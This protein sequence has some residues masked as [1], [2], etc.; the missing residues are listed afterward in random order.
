VLDYLQMA[1]DGALF[2][3]TYALV[4]I[5]FTLVFGVMRRINM[6]Y[7]AASLTAAY[8]GLTASWFAP[9]AALLVLAVSTVVGGAIGLVIYI[10]CF[11]FIPQ[12]NELATLL[13]SIGA[14]LTFEEL[15]VHATQGMPTAYPSIIEGRPWRLGLLSVRPDLVAVFLICCLA[16]AA[17]LFILYRTRLGMATRAISQQPV[18]ARLCGV[19]LQRIN[20]ST[21]ALT[22]GLGG[23][24][25]ALVGTAVGVLS[26]MLTLPLSIKGLIVAVIGG[27]GS[28]P[29]AIVAGI[30]IG[31]VENVFQ[32]FRGVTERDIYVMLLLF[33][34]LLLRPSGLFGR[35]RFRD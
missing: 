7:A 19:P 32:E 25:G 1:V 31:A 18:A 28:I 2:G 5:G 26:P 15:L 8:A 27:L 12:H 33:L 23:L 24:A 30:L 13:A 34:F 17:F 20:I 10:I 21:F 29:G 6:S 35:H 16:T 14:L 4:G 3:T 22:G 11:R 9:E